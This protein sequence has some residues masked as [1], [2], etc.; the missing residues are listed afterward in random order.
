MRNKLLAD[1]GVSDEGEK[2]GDAGDD[3]PD[4]TE[5]EQL[6]FL[7]NFHLAIL[8]FEGFLNH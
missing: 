7:L 6:K 3:S 4:D 2:P 1:A 8:S 5:R